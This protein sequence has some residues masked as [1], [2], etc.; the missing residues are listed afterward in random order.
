MS[1]SGIMRRIVYV[2]YTDCIRQCSGPMYIV[3]N[4]ALSVLVHAVS[5]SVDGYLSSFSSN[6]DLFP[7]A[8]LLGSHGSACDGEH[9]QLVSVS[10]QF[11]L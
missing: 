3:S 5:N 4:C 6:G 11:L 1:D 8:S 2:I 9:R 7:A 10:E